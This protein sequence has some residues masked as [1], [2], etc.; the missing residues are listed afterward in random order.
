MTS[1]IT[2]EPGGPA[3]PAALEARKNA[4][5]PVRA[6]IMRLHF[7]AGVFVGPFLIIAALS[8]AL[9]ALTPALEEGIYEQG[10]PRPRLP[11][12]RAAGRTDPRRAAGRRR[13]TTL[14]R[15]PGPETRGHDPDHVR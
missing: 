11:D 6:L 12:P 15:P 8:G 13:P 1:T 14:R 4:R 9:Y 3:S 2:T 10:T 5:G 7:Y